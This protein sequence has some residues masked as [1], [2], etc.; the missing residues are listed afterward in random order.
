M[1]ILF[2]LTGFGLSKVAGGAAIRIIE[3]AKRFSKWGHEIHFLTTESGKGAISRHSSNFHFHIVRSSHFRKEERSRID[4][5]ISYFVST[6]D[7]FI[8]MKNIS[9][10]DI[11]IS[12]DDYFCHTIPGFLYKKRYKNT[13]W[14]TY[15]H[16]APANI[17]LKRRLEIKDKYFQSFK[18]FLLDFIITVTSI[19]NQKLTFGL[20]LKECDK[21][22]VINSYEGILTK[23]YLQTMGFSRH[24]I[25]FFDNGVDLKFIKAVKFSK[26]KYDVCFL[27]GL[28]PSKGIFDLVPIWRRVVELMPNAKL[29]VV[30]GGTEDV[31]KKFKKGISNAGLDGNIEVLGNIP[32]R[33]KVFSLLKQ[34]RILIFPSHEDTWGIPICEAMACG[35]PVIAWN[36]KFYKYLYPK[37]IK[38][39]EIGDYDAFTR[40]IIKI[41]EDKRLYRTLSKDAKKLIQKYDWDKISLR[42]L[43]I[44]KRL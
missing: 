36:Y 10:F 43:E 32:N 41:L 24:R 28:R 13:K 38:L 35:L 33:Y 23:N 18:E 44:L 2:I 14:V 37:G 5:L 29:L 19:F 40:G 16:R 8:K 4:R 34:S 7:S 31:E 1:K 15:A 22:L 3:V 11:V 6:L 12:I 9:R 17:L 39:V 27:G 25:D 21:I 30:G 26:K 42:E 20:C